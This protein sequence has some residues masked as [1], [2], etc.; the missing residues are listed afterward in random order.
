LFLS[1]LAKSG[2]K[3]SDLR[4]EYPNYFISKNKIQ[5][6]PETDVE[7]I[8]EKVKENYEKQGVELNTID[9]IKIE[10]A[11]EWVQLRK[12]NTEPIIRVYAESKN[13]KSANK[14]AEKIIRE[15]EQLI[16]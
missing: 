16:D 4:A 12:S 6:K 1:H 14:L 11:A 9:G 3:C 2:K 7:N 13:E 10:F 8:L 15:I 5:L